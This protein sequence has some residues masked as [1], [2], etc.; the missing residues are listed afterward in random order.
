MKQI[1]FYISHP[2]AL[3]SR[4][5]AVMVS[6]ILHLAIILFF[7]T[8]PI[9]KDIPHSQIIFIA[10]SDEKAFSEARPALSAQPAGQPEKLMTRNNHPVSLTW[11]INNDPNRSGILKE[12]EPTLSDEKVSADNPSS[13][14]KS[15]GVSAATVDSAVGDDSVPAV[16]LRTGFAAG[17][18][19]ESHPSKSVAE[20]RFG[21]RGAPTFLYQEIPAYPTLA[22]RLGKEGRVLL[23]LLIDA[24]GKVVNVEVVEA[25][26][27]GFTEASVAAVKKSTYA[28]GYRDGVKVATR[29][30]LPVRFHLQ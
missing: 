23:K 10:F 18:R 1:G 25:A 11:A 3:N 7:Y 26:G 29:A 20:A 30:L 17:E 21:D 4:W 24:D 22:R 19:S 9:M 15:V 16:S 27:Y 14:K 5:T 8:A 13:A 2:F 6:L 12:S 28:P